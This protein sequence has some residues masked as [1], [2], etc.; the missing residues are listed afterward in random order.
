MLV[1]AS[2]VATAPEPG[3]CHCAQIQPPAGRFLPRL[4]GVFFPQTLQELNLG[5]PVLCSD[6]HPLTRLTRLTGLTSVLR[7]YVE[8][9]FIAL[10]SLTG[11]RRLEIRSSAA[12]IPIVGELTLLSHFCFRMFLGGEEHPSLDVAPLTRLRNLAHLGCSPFAVLNTKHQLATLGAITSLGSLTLGLSRGFRLTAPETFP[13]G[14]LSH[15]T[16]LNLRC[17]VFDAPALRMFN[18]GSLLS[19]TLSA[20]FRLDSAW[21][22]AL[23]QATMLTHM[24]TLVR[25]HLKVHSYYGGLG[26]L[27]LPLMRVRATRQHG[28]RRGR[29]AGSGFGLQEDPT[30]FKTENGL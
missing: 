19:L 4:Q 27:Q 13:F 3:V 17:R 8:N 30:R 10:S 23:G 26:G 11:L 25:R 20:G 2:P 6:A 18:M 16:A 12:V 1:I 24:I 14:P 22:G 28:N 21:V 7:D 5:P 29:P 9:P 15:L